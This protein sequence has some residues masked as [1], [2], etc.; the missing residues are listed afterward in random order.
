M[1]RLIGVALRIGQRLKLNT[2]SISTK[3]EREALGE[4]PT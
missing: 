4:G 1:E 2:G 3:E